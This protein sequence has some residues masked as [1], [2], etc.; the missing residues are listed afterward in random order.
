ML[1]VDHDIKIQ[2]IYQD[3]S[4]VNIFNYDNITHYNITNSTVENSLAGEWLSDHDGRDECKKPRVIHVESMDKETAEKAYEEEIKT[5]GGE[6][7]P[8]IKYQNTETGVFSF[9]SEDWPEIEPAVQDN[10]STNN[11]GFGGM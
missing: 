8:P 9:R 7:K 5:Q 6:S 11:P 1:N 4:L 10:T 2:L 3:I